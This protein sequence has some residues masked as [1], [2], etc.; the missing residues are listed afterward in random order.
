M[1]LS[2]QN[3]RVNNLNHQNEILYKQNREIKREIL[4]VRQAYA[5]AKEIS[6]R[7]LGKL[8]TKRDELQAEANSLDSATRQKV[9][10]KKNM[11]AVSN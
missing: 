3:S 2:G 6:D 9:Q 8:T 10:D 4:M 5:E 7:D 11:R 1:D